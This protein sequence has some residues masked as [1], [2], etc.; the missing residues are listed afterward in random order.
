[1]MEG[2]RA[3]IHHIPQILE[4]HVGLNFSDRGRGHQVVSISSFRTKE[5]LQMYTNHIEHIRVVRTL[6]DPIRE[7]VTVGDIEC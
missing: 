4:M 7:S 3:L 2:L 6:V 5:D 1:M